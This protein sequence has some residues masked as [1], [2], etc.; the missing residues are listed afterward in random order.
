[1]DLPEKAIAEDT[2]ALAANPADVYAILNR[3]MIEIRQG[4]LE[5]ARKDFSRSVEILPTPMTWFTLGTILER[6]K[7][8][9]A[10]IQAYQ[11]ALGMNPNLAD[12]QSRLQTL[13]Q[14]LPH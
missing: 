2:A 1:M 7:D 13:R 3:G 4:D 5:G 10:A 11:S 6:Q 12:A 9:P 14:Q 8:I